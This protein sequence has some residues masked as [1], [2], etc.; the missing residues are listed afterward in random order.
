M[1]IAKKGNW[2]QKPRPDRYSDKT[3]G[4]IRQTLR[5][6]PDHNELIRKAAE[7]DGLSI[8]NW[9]VRILVKTA[10]KQVAAIEPAPRKR[11]KKLG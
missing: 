3:E 1:T 5:L 10:K 9:A 7:A 11:V 4:L 8:N 2:R 6:N